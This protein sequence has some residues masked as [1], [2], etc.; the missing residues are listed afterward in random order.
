MSTKKPFRNKL[1][2]LLYQAIRVLWPWAS[3]T[4]AHRLGNDPSQ[5]HH[6]DEVNTIGQIGHIMPAIQGGIKSLHPFAKNVGNPKLTDVAISRHG[7]KIG[8]RVG[9]NTNA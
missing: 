9:I 6:T 1:E 3:F 4:N 2:G 7:Y 5:I 8:C